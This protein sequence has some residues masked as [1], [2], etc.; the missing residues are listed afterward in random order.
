MRQRVQHGGIGARPQRQM[1]IGLDMRHA[2]EV[3]AAWIDHDQPGALAQPLLH[4]RGEDRMSVG[5]IGADHQD[6]VTLLDR[7]EIL[8]ARRRTERGLQPIAGRRVTDAGAGIDIVVAEAAA[9][10]LLHQVGFLVGAARGGDA[11]D[12][13]PSIPALQALELRGDPVDRHLPAHL[14]PRLVDTL[15]DHRLQDALAMVGVAPGEAALY[16][17][18]AVIGLAVLVGD[19]AHEF[20]AAHL[21]L[22]A[23]ADAAIGAGRHH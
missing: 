14:A 2:H 9:D 18:M 23:A 17:G 7:I 5:R 10:Q 11:A 16:A 22:E 21:G 3:G 12:R 8:G 13:Q 4:A 20:L 15:A 1:I 19:H 6:H